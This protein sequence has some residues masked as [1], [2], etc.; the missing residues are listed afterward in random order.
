MNSLLQEEQRAASG[1]LLTLSIVTEGENKGWVWKGRDVMGGRKGRENR[2]IQVLQEGA[3][4][5][6][7]GDYVGGGAGLR[8]LMEK[9]CFWRGGG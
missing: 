3:E 1:I 2:S 6:G 4:K 9:S 7:E 5:A 8:K